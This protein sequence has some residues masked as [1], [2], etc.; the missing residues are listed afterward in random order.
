MRSRF[1]LA[2]IELVIMTLVFSLAAALCLK[3]FACAEFISATCR[4]RDRAVLLAVSTAEKIKAAHSA[5]ASVVLQDGFIITVAPQE[6]GS[7]LLGSAVV[8]VAYAGGST[9]A[10]LAV[11]WQ[12]DGK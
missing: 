4:E 7:S 9:L 12:E 2:L 3:A 6:S 10:E 5:E 8:S 1:P 11:K